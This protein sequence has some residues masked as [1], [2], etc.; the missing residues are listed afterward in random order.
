LLL[1]RDFIRGKCHK[2]LHRIRYLA[3]NCFKNDTPIQAYIS[4]A[5]PQDPHDLQQR[6]V[7]MVED[8]FEANITTLLDIVQL[9]PGSDV[10]QYLEKIKSSHTILWIGTPELKSSIVF[11]P[12]TKPSTNV[13]IEFHHIKDKD[14]TLSKQ[15]QL[16]SS[17][18]WSIQALWFHG[19]SVSDAFP[20]GHNLNITTHDF[21]HERDYYIRLPQLTASIFGIINTPSF[22][23]E[24]LNYQ[25]N[26]KQW[27]NSFSLSD[28]NSRL[29][30]EEEKKH[31]KELKFQSLLNNMPSSYIKLQYAQEQ[32]L[33]SRLSDLKHNSLS[34]NTPHSHTLEFYIP[35]S[36][37]PDLYSGPHQHFEAFSK[38]SSFIEGGKNGSTM[39]IFGAAGGGKSLFARFLEK[40]LWNQWHGT[41]E[42]VPIFIPLSHF[43]SSLSSHGRCTLISDF[44]QSPNFSSSDIVLLQTTFCFLF[45][46]DGLD[47]VSLDVLP[48]NNFLLHTDLGSWLDGHSNRAVVLCRSQHVPILESRLGTSIL[49]YFTASTVD[50]FHLMPFN[51]SQIKQF[52]AGYAQSMESQFNTD[53]SPQEYEFHIEK[54]NGLASLVQSPFL[55]KL[56]AKI[57]PRLI[58]VKV[59]REKIL[60]LCFFIF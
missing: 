6:L 5:W 11:D 55:L 56:I 23:K 2:F 20:D 36:G 10:K 39:L 24:F 29:Q 25:N 32:A 57:L 14:S 26:V 1:Q 45:I 13:A 53:W 16:S 42:L 30:K 27:E 58:N 3:S 48:A 47:E 44:L 33:L 31:E 40:S 46:L 22:K 12:D 54:T 15:L 52:L 19:K 41:Q 21:T 9:Q 18:L 28:I 50:S 35:L 37:G 34:S 17:P 59:Q 60:V 7:D 51:D 38:V 8:L 49:Q 4:Y 43:S